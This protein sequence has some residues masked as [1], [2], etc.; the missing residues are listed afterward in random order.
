MSELWYETPANGWD[1]ALP[2]GNGRL[3]AMV[4]GR[5]D[6]E[7]LQLNEDSVWYGGPQN[8]LPEDAAEHL[9]RLREL[10]RNGAHKEAEKLVRRA[11]FASPNSQRHYEP[12]GTLSLEFGHLLDDVQNYRRSLD[13][14]EGIAHVQ[15]ECNGVQF[16]RQVL[17]SH[18][19]GVLAIRIQASQRTEFL[20]RVSRLSEVEYETN[21]FMDDLVVD[22]RTISMHITPGGNGSNRANCRI[23][24]RCE[25]EPGTIE[26]LGKNLIVNAKDALVLIAAQSTYRHKDI[27]RA[28]IADLESALTHSTEDIWKR[29]ITDYQALYG[30]L[31]LQLGPDATEI[32]TD[33][34]I[35]SARDPGLIALYLHYSRDDGSDRVLPATLQGIWNPSFHPPWGCRYTININLQMNY[36]P[37]NVGNLSEC[38]QP[39]FALLERIAEAGTETA[40]KMYGC[41]GWTVHHN[42]DLWADTAPVDRWMPA[43]LWPLGGAW[44]CIHIW[45]HFRFTGDKKA[46]ARMHPVLRGYDASGQ[47]KV[48]NPSLSPENTFRDGKGEVGV[49]CEGSTIDIQLVLGRSDELLPSVHDTLRRL[50]PLRIGSAGQLQEWMTDHDEV[51]P[52]HRHVSHLWALY[53]GCDIT[54]EST[55]DLAKACAVTLQRRQG[56]GGGHTGWS[57]A[58]LLNLHARLRDADECAEHLERLLAQST[59]P[60]LL[61]THPPF[62]IDGNFGGGAGILEMLVQSHEEAA[63]QSGRLRGVRARGGF[64]LEFSWEDGVIR[65]PVIV[66]SELG[67]RAVVHYPNNGPRKTRLGQVQSTN[68]TTIMDLTPVQDVKGALRSDFFHGYATAAAQVEGAWNKDGKGPS[69]WDTFGHTPGKVK[70]NST[71]DDAV[72]AY[73]FYRED[74]ALMKSYGV[75]AYRF[76]LSWSRIIPLGGA[77]DPVNE[78]GIKFYQ[79]FVDELLKNGITPFVT[80]FHWDV[81]QALEDRYG[82]M[83]NQEKF[84]PDFVR[85]ARV[86]FESLPRVRHWITFNEPGVYSLAGY[87][88]GV[89]APAR[90]SFRDLNE[91]GDSSTEPFIVSHTELVAHGHVSKLYREEFKAQQQGTIGITL[92]G[93][94]SEPYDEEDPRDQEA[95]ERAREFEIAWFADPLYKTGDY[96]A[97]MRAQ[98]GDRLPRFTPEESKLVLGSSEFYGMNSYTT[99]F[100]QHKDTPPDI[101]DHKGN[102]HVHDTNSKGVSR[103]EESDTAWLRMAPGGFRKLLNWIWN[104]YHVPIYVTENGTTAKGETAPTPE[105][106]NDQFRIRFFEGYVGGIARA[107]K[108]DGVDIRSYFA[109]TFTDNWGKFSSKSPLVPLSR[110]SFASAVRPPTAPKPSPDIKHIRQNPEIY[111]QNCRDRNYPSHADYPFKIQQLS[112]ELRQIDQQLIPSRSRIKTLEKTIGRLQNPATDPKEKEQEPALRAE[113]QQL[114]EQSLEL[115]NRSSSFTEQINELALSLPNLSSSH[116]PVGSEPTLVEYLNFDPQSP[117][118]WVHNPDASRSHVAIG[119]T[120]GLIDFASAATTTGWGWYFLIGDGAILEQALIQYSLSVARRH[121]WSPVS[122]PSIVYSYVADACGFQPRDQNNEQQIWAIEQAEKDKSKPQRSLTATAEIPLA[123]MHAGRDL[124]PS[125]LPLKLAGPSRCYRA[126][127]GSRGVDTKGLY[128]VHEFTK[129]EMFGWAD[130]APTSS[131]PSSDELF[132]NLLTVQ[133]EIL[134]S[135]HLPCRILEMPTTDLGA[136]ATR[137]RDI[138]ALFPSR[139]RGNGLDDA[140]GEVT[141][142]S[143]CTDYQSRRLGTRVRGGSAKETRFPHTVNGTAMAVPRVLAAILENGWD[144]DR[145]VVVIPEVLRPYMGGAEVIGK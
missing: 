98:L 66:K 4:Y 3:G 22:D 81:P 63:W 72:R 64:E 20:V 95:A 73:D 6:T 59:L 32:P 5:T 145:Q 91:E 113:A 94:W 143:I 83:L 126:E 47:Y 28:T 142:A 61:D 82:G 39:L 135:L 18:P 70:D 79:D 107:V 109:W 122:P 51:E 71:A 21:E 27:D 123:A 92:H 140:W 9:T 33:R 106:L 132:E 12:L 116:T 52:G 69:I 108:E 10:I 56:A 112:D 86:C 34:R 77:E 99:F 62:Q 37:A 30:R 25:N 50:P 105:V 65:G 11:F 96:P 139:M 41:R 88:A 68:G 111:S 117:P 119:S 127:A 125:A 49:L 120:L 131:S 19:D 46:L 102:V 43:T 93:N 13:L 129:V 97:S 89:H 48:T 144:A 24:I 60:N 90:S 115:T 103:G 14:K 121:G 75:N 138:E 136:S 44:L 100:V 133:K 17:A 1:E 78:Q 15:Y 134:T 54:L 16:H 58:W 67:L 38:E 87:A 85:Y 45:E 40:R 55:P 8:R 137:K 36:W 84:V 57:R 53:P 128:R 29:H 23:S 31:E 26:R 141:S 101:N 110:R 80:L 42:T 130:N 74:V 7:L 124:D 114:K 76:S 118:S 35:Q 2:V 104:R